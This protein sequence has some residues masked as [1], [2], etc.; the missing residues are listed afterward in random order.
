MNAPQQ[1]FQLHNYNALSGA[2][3]GFPVGWDANPPGGGAN[4]RFCQ[5]F[6]KNCMKLQTFWA[7]GGKRAPGAPPPLR[8]ATDYVSEC[9]GYEYQ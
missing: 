5:N 9:P 3:S 6:P 8:F 7:I 2:D 1:S 4:L